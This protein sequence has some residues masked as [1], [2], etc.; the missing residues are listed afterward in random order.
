MM[1]SNSE[2][3]NIILDCKAGRSYN[4]GKWNDF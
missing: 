4:K 2:E 3:C 1:G